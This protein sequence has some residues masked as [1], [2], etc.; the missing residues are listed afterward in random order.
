MIEASTW[1]RQ[2][3][4]YDVAVYFID[5]TMKSVENIARNRSIPNNIVP[6]I[7]QFSYLK[8]LLLAVLPVQDTAVQSTGLISSLQ[9]SPDGRF[10]L[11]INDGTYIKV[12]DM[13]KGENISYRIYDYSTSGNV[14]VASVAFTSDSS[15]AAIAG[16]RG[17]VGV[18]E[19][20]SGRLLYSWENFYNLSSISGIRFN[21]DGDKIMFSD[22][23]QTEF[24]VCS[25]RNGLVIY[26]MHADGPVAEWGFDTDSGDAVI[27]YESGEALA[28][29][30][31]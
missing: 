30:I 23:R 9:I 24:L 29:E 5:N 15:L 2:N 14:N 26:D 8:I 12:W 19:L 20:E 28:A 27:V 21:P 17:N 7:F 16:G 22:Y 4:A 10:V 1:G 25:V 31:F 13:K 18:Y 3:P 11:L 6:I